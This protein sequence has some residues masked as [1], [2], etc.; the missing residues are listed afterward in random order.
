MCGG[1]EVECVVDG[2]VLF[3]G[4]GVYVY[5]FD[6]MKFYVF[7]FF[8]KTYAL[9]SSILFV[10]VSVDGVL[11]FVGFFNVFF[12]YDID[13]VKLIKWSVVFVDVGV[14][15]LIVFREMFG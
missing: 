10:V 6:M 12:M 4:G 5:N 3:F 11:V 1:D 9:W 14:D 15:V 13:S 8:L 2:L 7:L